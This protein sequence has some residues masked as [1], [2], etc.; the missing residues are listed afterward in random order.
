MEKGDQEG[1]CMFS[2][3]EKPK[4]GGKKDGVAGELTEKSK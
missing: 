4:S 3:K 1:N 2:E